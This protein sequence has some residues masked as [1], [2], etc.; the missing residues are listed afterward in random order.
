MSPLRK[1]TL[2]LLF[3]GALLAHGQQFTRGLGVY[4][5][6]PSQ[7]DGP[8]LA[9]DATSY[10]NLALHRPA[11][12]SSA[13]DYNLTAQLVTDGIV[14]HELPQWIDASTN[15]RPAVSKSERNFLIDGNLATSLRG[16]GAHPWVELD[17]MGG[18]SVPTIDKMQV[19]LRTIEAPATKDGWSITIEGSDDRAHWSTVGSYHGDR[20]HGNKIDDLAFKVPVNFTAPAHFRSYRFSFAGE[21]VAA[22]D[23]TQVDT[24]NAGKEVFLGRNFSSAWMSEGVGPEWVSVDLGARCHFDRVVLDWISRPGSGA[25]QISDDGKEWKTLAVIGNA[26]QNEH[27]SKLTDIDDLHLSADARWVRVQMLLPREAGKNYILS[28]LEVWGTGGPVAHPQ[29]AEAAKKGEPLRLTRGNWKL[30]R[31]SEVAADGKQLATPGFDDARWLTATVPGTVLTS[32]L[33]AGAVA[34]PNFGHNEFTISDAYFNADFWYRNEFLA[35]ASS[36]KDAH[37]WLNFEG[38]NWKAEVYLNGSY[39]GRIDGAFNRGRFDVTSLLKPGA[40]NAVAVRIIALDHPGGT[41][42]KG[43]QWMNGGAP[44]HDAPNF[45]ATVGWDWMSTIRGRDTGIWNNVTL[46]ETGS[47]RIEDPAVV[48]HLPLPSTD[49]ADVALSTTLHNL[50]SKSVKGRLHADFGSIAIDQPVELAASS[51]KSVTLDAAH[52]KALHI[53][54]PHLWW[55]NGYGDPYLYPVKL[56]FI[57]DGAVSDSTHFNTGIRQFAYSEEGNAL[58]MWINGK[59]FIPRGGNWGFSESMLRYRAREYD[60]AM[61]FHREEN[62]NMARNWVGSTADEAFFDAADRNGIVIWQD[63]W[64]ANPWDGPEPDNE[65]I[66]MTNAR[67]TVLRIRNHAAMGLY[68]GRNEGYP[69][70]SL[71]AAMRKLITELAPDTHYIP[72]SADGVVEGRGP[73]R[74]LPLRAYFEGTAPKLHS[75]IGSPNVPDAATMERTL[76]SLE[77][78]SNATE[79]RQHDFDL[80]DHFTNLMVHE[81]GPVTSA[82]DYIKLAQFI[83]YDAY[84]AMFESDAKNRQGILIWMSHAAW[85]SIL[86]QTY[87]YFYD[88][89]AAYYASMHATEPLHIQWNAATNMVELVNYSAG[90]HKALTASAEILDLSGKVQWQK[91]ATLASNEDSTQEAFALELPAKISGTHFLRLALHEEGK[92]VSSNFYLHGAKED[93][94]S[95]IR[96]LAPAKVSM[97]STLERHGEEWQLT[98]TLHNDSNVPA[99]HLRVKTVR[100]ASGD[101]ILPAFYSDN[102]I[103]LMPGEER[104]IRG[105]FR[106]A[107]TR[108]EAPRLTLEGFN[109]EPAK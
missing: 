15:S 71:D 59:R 39:V 91:S 52:F 97:K 50:S 55:P 35:P 74:V 72:S 13:F 21:G 86:W 33:N 62:F 96:S 100:S 73:Y 66:F 27:D 85:P 58:R 53:V 30:E 90:T 105:S 63:F 40:N 19:W 67:D 57:A 65:A 8:T 5:G 98:A 93:D 95:G 82:T 61:R 37:F 104:T 38:I 107:D 89:D 56:T 9:P 7:Y 101:L 88:T 84:R 11:Y 26:T 87:D 31:A 25:L 24:Y 42:D 29:P 12:Q 36:K 10:R 102:Y 3:A 80:A 109:L 103:A 14:S 60:T 81:F 51:S 70:A 47:V 41:K 18:G 23:M 43:G 46:S 1:A 4:P 78:W 83:D 20:F 106:Q 92:L 28:E 45:H 64:L 99:L 68:C 76:S 108:G 34:D 44:G 75:E 54:N 48:S 2:L 32:Y 79:W 16:D 69:P 94:Y 6:E 17:V 77:L 49:S 22:W